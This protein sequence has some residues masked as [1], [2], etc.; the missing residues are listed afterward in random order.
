MARSIRDIEKI[1]SNVEGVRKLSD[2]AVGV[3]PFGIGMDGLLTWIPWVGDVYT[4]GAG[5]WLM[6]QAMRA[7]ATPGTLLKM[8]AYLASD[9]A[10]A[11]IPFG[12]AVVDTLW[13][14][15]AMAARAL[16]KDIE[17]TH[18][19]EEH[20]EEAKASGAHAGHVEAGRAAGKTRVVYLGRPA[21]R[22]ITSGGSGG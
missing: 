11:A 21:P 15:H 16:Q 9:T 6:V 3:G 5:G 14:A 1:W 2:R 17:A 22:E 4:V 10:T 19:V 13:P 12:G 18:W 20:E 7:Q 8:A